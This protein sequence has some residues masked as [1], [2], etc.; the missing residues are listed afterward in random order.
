VKLKLKKI[1]SIVAQTL[2]DRRQSTL[3][4]SQSYAVRNG[5]GVHQIVTQCLKNKERELVFI[6]VLLTHCANSQNKTL[7]LTK[8]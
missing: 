8:G 1:V 3:H 4:N 5:A 7:K 6:L 2:R